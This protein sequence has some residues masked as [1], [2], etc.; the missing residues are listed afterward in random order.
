MKDKNKGIIYISI[1][2]LMFS[3]MAVFVKLTPN[4][5]VAEK[6]F[7]RNS[8]GLIPILINVKKTDIS[9]KPNNTKLVILRSTFGVLGIFSYYTALELLN[10]A[11]AVILNKL[12]PFFVLILSFVFLKENISKK[13]IFALIFALIGALLVIQP[14]FDLS[15]VPTLIGVLSGFLAGC[16]YTTVRKLSESDHPLV[17]VFYFALITTIAMIP[18]MIFNNQ[19]VIPTLKQ[20]ILLSM[21]ALSALIAQLFMTNAYRHAPAGELAIYSYLN[22]IF[23]LIFGIIIWSEVPGIL[24]FTGAIF[25]LSAGYINYISKKKA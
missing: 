17:I 6:I 15:I 18:V 12:S 9:L 4:I 21:I 19:F 16:S 2:A 24:T 10:L 23:S 13:Q 25:I 22:I 1:S 8:L 3:L 11:D 20:F 5:P 7:F 14:K